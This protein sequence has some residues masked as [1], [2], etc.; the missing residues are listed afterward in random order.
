[1]PD[2]VVVGVVALVAALVG[3]FVALLIRRSFALNSEA[4]A[5]A[6]S[7]RLVAEARAKQKEILLEAKDE[8]IKVAK[9]AEAENKERRSELQRFETR[10]DKKDQQ[11]DEQASAL[12]EREKKLAEKE[13]AI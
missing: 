5:R 8:A 13:Q 6:N 1:M 3:F 9:A 12:V 7:E 4:T 10:I 11:L 2:I